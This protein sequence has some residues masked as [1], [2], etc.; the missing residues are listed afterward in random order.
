V[1]RFLNLGGGV[2]SSTWF[3]LPVAPA[4]SIPDDWTD[5]QGTAWRQQTRN[6]T[7]AGVSV[8]AGLVF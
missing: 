8:F 4:F 3:D 2:F 7:F 1:A 5:V 6:L